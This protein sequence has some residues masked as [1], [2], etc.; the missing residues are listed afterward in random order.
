MISIEA[1][2]IPKHTA[3]GGVP[4]TL[5]M[6]LE[7]TARGGSPVTLSM[8]LENTARGGGSN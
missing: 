1:P 7:N 2:A 3:R 8:L 5:S 4:V 6:L